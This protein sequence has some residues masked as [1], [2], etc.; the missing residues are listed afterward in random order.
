MFD[1]LIVGVD[2]R[3]GGRDAAALAQLPAADRPRVA[4]VHVYGRT[5]GLPGADPSL[6]AD[7]RDEAWRVVD[8]ER[9]RDWPA[10]EVACACALTVGHGL[11]RLALERDAEPIVAGTSR[12]GVASRLLA[13]DESPGMT[14]RTLWA[15]AIAPHGYAVTAHQLHELAVAGALERRAD[16]PLLMV[17]G[18]HPPRARRPATAALADEAS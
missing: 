10:A 14:R 18:D 5:A 9:A 15:V 12:R 11:R 1:N 6:L 3:P 2:G 16:I 8:R 17:A 7:E 4:L 13:G